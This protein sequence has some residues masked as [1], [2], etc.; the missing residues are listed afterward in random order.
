MEESFDSLIILL[1]PLKLAGTR[2]TRYIVLPLLEH[3][4]LCGVGREVTPG[5]ENFFTAIADDLARPP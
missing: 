4:F 3:P 2:E 5:A 1:G